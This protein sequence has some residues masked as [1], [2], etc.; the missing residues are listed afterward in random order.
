M[1]YKVL[2]LKWRPKTFADVIGQEHVVSAIT[3]GFSLGKV[4]HAYLLTGIRGVGKTTIARLF[5]KGL[6]C[7]EK[8]VSFPCCGK[9]KNCLDIERGRFI[10]FIEIDAASRTKIEDIRDLLDDMQYSPVSAD[11]KLYLIDEV[12]MLSRHSFNALLKILEEPPEYVKFVLLTTEKYKLPATVLSRC[13]Q[14][15][16]K[17][18]NADQIF[19]YL[20]FV[21]N[22]EQIEYD[23]YVVQLLAD[24][25]NGSI[26]D[27]LTLVDQAIA[28]GNNKIKSD[29]VKQMFGLLSPKQ[30]FY[31]LEALVQADG[32]SLMKKVSQCAL[33]G[34]DWEFLLV[35]ILS[36]LHKL[37]VD[38]VLPIQ[39]DNDAEL[40]V[41]QNL[42]TL[43][44][45]LIPTDLQL[46]YQILLIGRKELPF[47]P[48][49]RMGI[50]MTLLR[51]LAFHPLTNKDFGQDSSMYFL[52]EKNFDK[53]RKD[54]NVTTKYCNKKINK[55]KN[56]LVDNVKKCVS[57]K[58]LI[59]QDVVVDNNQTSLI[60][61][62]NL[63][64]EDTV[65]LLQARSI[66]NQYK[67]NKKNEKDSNIL[68][69]VSRKKTVV[70]LLKRFAEINQHILKN[71]QKVVEDDYKNNSILVNSLNI[72]SSVQKE[73]IN[74]EIFFSLMKKVIIRDPWS[75]Q[76]N[77]L[78]LSK[79][80]K[81]LAL[82]SWKKNISSNVICLYLRS[83]F[84]YLNSKIV[85]DEIEKKLSDSLNII[86]NLNIEINDDLSVKTPL[87]WCFFLYDKKSTKIKKEILQD[88]SVKKLQDFFDVELE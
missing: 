67:N 27:A 7:I 59:L 39:V 6:N 43:S 10:D 78:S 21:L 63:I 23:S 83:K 74:N 80:A 54:I 77:K 68:P 46:L 52:D 37:A 15:H 14:L 19:N 79:Q 84:H 87:E 12:H 4:H 42:R 33:L 9:C 41:L 70:N 58:N 31:I 44:H 49:Y 88:S 32:S 22:K 17:A 16:L 45:Y 51:A 76:I 85:R 25:A 72:N 71:S 1:S 36:L 53:L 64:S 61:N 86:I 3:N 8:N 73:N 62:K 5:A 57:N 18:L 29:V 65:N 60:A 28:L 50:E 38:Q 2:A 30:P 26:R 75:A 69:I 81:R 13:F 48:N 11:S 20:I 24:S 40:K 34:V 56:N 66:L 55:I 82:N 47:A 35:E